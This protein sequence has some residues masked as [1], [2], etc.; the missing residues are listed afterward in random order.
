MKTMKTMKTITRNY[1]TAIILTVMITSNAQGQSRMKEEKDKSTTYKT[2]KIDD[3]D[4]F[5]REAGDEKKPTLLLLHG[6]PTSS[7]MFR[8]LMKD[9]SSDY[10][11]IAPD[12]PGFGRSSQPA[13]SEFDY[14][15]ENMSIIIE[16]LLKQLNIN[17]YSIYLMDYG[18]PI[19]FRIAAKHP[20]E[21]RIFNHPKWKCL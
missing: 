11:L 15:F 19:G 21:S 5:Y 12:Y 7:H 8:N 6:Y 10:H 14:T 16:K 18:A 3:L 9:L 2:V 4:I 17:K 13:M 1:L 20:E